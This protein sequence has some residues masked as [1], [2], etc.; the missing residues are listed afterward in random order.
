MFLAID[1]GNTNIVF[2]VFDGGKLLTHW[3]VVTSRERTADEYRLLLKELF[4]LDGVRVSSIDGIAV[5]CVVPPVIISL[6]KACEALYSIK[7]VLIGPG[8]KT[9][10]SI[11]YDN[12]REVGADRIVNAVAGYDKYRKSIIIVDFGTATTFDCVSRRGE[13]LGGVIAPGIGISLEALFTHASKL[14]RIEITAPPGVIGTNTVNSMQSGIF[15]GYIA[16]VEGIIRLATKEMGEDKP[17]VIATGGFA[18]LI[19]SASSLIDEVD[20]FLT[21]RGL[22]IIYDKNIA[23]R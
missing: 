10:I 17:A 22:K 8:I 6:E 16:L 18:E 15:Y 11:L 13:Y 21:L 12:P 3:R 20:E 23:K 2:G 7:P 1:V 19:G 9:G 5:S 4:A 14:P